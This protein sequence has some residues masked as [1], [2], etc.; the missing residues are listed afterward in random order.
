MTYTDIL[1][2]PTGETVAVEFVVEDLET[3]EA[4]S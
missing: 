1:V 4:Q 3:V 2:T